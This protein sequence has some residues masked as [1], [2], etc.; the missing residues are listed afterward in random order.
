MC[1]SVSMVFMFRL[2]IMHASMPRPKL[3]STHSSHC[4]A[5]VLSAASRGGRVF[6][7]VLWKVANQNGFICQNGVRPVVDESV[8]RCE[9]GAW[10]FA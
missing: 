5:A 3:A 9:G 7:L 1:A 10:N 6:K 2:L 4:C 8:D